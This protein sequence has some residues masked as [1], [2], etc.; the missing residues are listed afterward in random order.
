MT[1]TL[2]ITGGSTPLIIPV[3]EKTAARL[4]EQGV[5][6]P[7]AVT[8]NLVEASI[9]ERRKLG[10]R[11]TLARAQ[12]KPEEFVAELMMLRATVGTD[13][14]VVRALVDDMTPSATAKVVHA[15]T[16]GDLPNA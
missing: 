6:A 1:L 8:L 5:D 2:D 16:H 13:E 4:K 7:E 9:G 10:E 11:E 15:C 12:D 3:P 14:R